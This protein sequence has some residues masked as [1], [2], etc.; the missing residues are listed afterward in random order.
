MSEGPL[1]TLTR[2]ELEAEVLRLRAASQEAL[3]DKDAPR[4]PSK[5]RSRAVLE[6]TT[7]FAIVVCDREGLITDWKDRKSVV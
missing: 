6:S 3:P 7:Q 2:A 1:A 4:R 5:A